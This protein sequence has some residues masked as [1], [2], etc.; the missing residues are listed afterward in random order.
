MRIPFAVLILAA[1]AVPG[2][3]MAQTAGQPGAMVAQCPPSNQ[4]I[5]AKG[6]AAAGVCAGALE[7][8]AGIRA[9]AGNAP[10]QQIMNIQKA[11][12]FFA[13]LPMY[14]RDEI[15]ANASTFIREMGGCLTNAGTDEARRAVIAEVGKI[16]QGCFQSA[17]QHAR[18]ASQAQPAPQ[19]GVQPAPVQP[20]PLE[21]VPQPQ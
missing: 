17:A 8:A 12:D 9:E 16:A 3:A 5:V 7:M 18:G 1:A 15:A 19:P 2:P 4:K 14:S 10:P 11:R 20:L 13:E 21:P 6:A